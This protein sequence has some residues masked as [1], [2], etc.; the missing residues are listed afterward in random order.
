MRLLVPSS[1]WL[2]MKEAV[3]FSNA[4]Q[5]HNSSRISWLA[6]RLGWRLLLCFARDSQPERMCQSSWSQAMW[7]K[8]GSRNGRDGLGCRHCGKVCGEVTHVFQEPAVATEE[9]G[10]NVIGLSCIFK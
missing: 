9:R 3:L 6:G 2:C 4:R 7:S 10:P 1:R 5:K 8:A